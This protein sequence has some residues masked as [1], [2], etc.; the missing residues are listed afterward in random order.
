MTIDIRRALHFY[1]EAARVGSKDGAQRASAIYMNGDDAEELPRSGKMAR[2]WMRTA[3]EL[4]DSTAWKVD[5][6]T[7]TLGM[8][9]WTAATEDQNDEDQE[10]DSEADENDESSASSSAIDRKT[11][12]YRK[13]ALEAW[14][15]G[16]LED[17]PECLNRIAEFQVS[18]GRYDK[19]VNL[20]EKAVNRAGDPSAVSSLAKFHASIIDSGNLLEDLNNKKKRKQYPIPIRIRKAK[21]ADVAVKISTTEDAPAD[22]E[23]K[24][25]EEEEEEDTAVSVGDE[26]GGSDIQL[27]PDSPRT[28]TQKYLKYNEIAASN[29]D[30]MSML[31]L[32]AS[33]HS[34]L[35][36]IELP[37]LDT[38]AMGTEDGVKSV[39]A[40]DDQSKSATT[41]K[42][43]LLPKNPALALDLYL[44]SIA[45]GAPRPIVPLLAAAQLLHFGDTGVAA[46]PARALELYMN[47]ALSDSAPPGLILVLADALKEGWNGGEPD[48]A[49]AFELYEHGSKRDDPACL[50]RCGDCLRQ[51]EGCGVDK[52]A[53]MEMYG[54]AGELGN[55]EAI[56][57]L[58]DLECEMG[59]DYAYLKENGASMAERSDAKNSS[60][61]FD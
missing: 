27:P 54:K 40:R 57:K 7:Y 36:T 56:S 42:V 22:A 18:V 9:Y 3:A 5:R 10:V 33:F 25:E 28:I 2:H 35:P 48:P 61:S 41:T 45:A 51:G 59:F 50:L 16:A 17:D 15:Q 21:K 53:A 34:G 20:W 32:A 46:D 44:K 58:R 38:T 1:E 39:D 4:G 19:A 14:R 31:H 23:D 55:G 47:A 13:L 6:Y 24:S 37:I 26:Q 30:S 43:N 29:G 11:R 60:E 52:P 8:W 49:K 12:K